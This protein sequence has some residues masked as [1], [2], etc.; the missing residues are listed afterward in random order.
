MDR[1]LISVLIPAYNVEKYIEKCVRSV[2]NQ[3]YRNLEVII[4]DDGSTDKTGEIA[5]HLAEEDSRIKVFHQENAGLA[6]TRN[7]LIGYALGDYIMQLDSDDYISEIAVEILYE[8]LE[9]TGANLSVGSYVSGDNKDHAF[10]KEIHTEPEVFSGD[11]K[12][13]KLFGSD[14]LVFICAWAKLYA[15]DLFKGLKYPDNRIHE[16]EYLAHYI[17]DRAETVVYINE[18][19]LYYTVEKTSISR[20]SFSLKRLDGV[21]ALLDRNSF[22]EKKGNEEL[23]RL[24]YLDFLKRFQY[25]Y[26]GVKYNYP[27]ETELTER[28]FCQ[29]KNVYNKASDRSLLGLKEKVLFGLF[30]KNPWINYQARKVFKK[31][32]IDT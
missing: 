27:E 1:P 3:T 23:L 12:Y 24:C 9:K 20:S 28:L 17:L 19:I 16:D 6:T 26:Y 25:Y 32:A 14:K 2:L 22:F 31:K 8:Y 29:Y 13:R 21:P 30:I 11:D 4:I 18:P 7:R 10:P 5:D 15:R